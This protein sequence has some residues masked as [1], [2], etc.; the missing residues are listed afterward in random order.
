[1][2]KIPGSI[3]LILRGNVVRRLLPHVQAPCSCARPSPAAAGAAGK[4]AGPSM[5]TAAARCLIL[6]LLLSLSGCALFQKTPPVVRPAPVRQVTVAR[7]ERPEP[8]EV[9]P[10]EPPKPDAGPLLHK[11]RPKGGR[12]RPQP[13]Q[14]ADKTHY[15]LL[16][17]N[18][19][20]EKGIASWYGPS[21]QGRRTSCGE[22]FDMHKVS[23]AHKLLPMHTRIQVTNLENGKAIDLTVNDRGPYVTGR[24]LDLSYGAAKALGVVDKGLARVRICTFDALP[25]ERN[26]DLAG[27]FLIHIGSFEK[28]ADALVLLKDMKS[29]NYKPSLLKVVTS[30]RG[31]ETRFRVEVGPYGSMSAANR[32]HSRVIGDYPSAFVVAR[33]DEEV[34]VAASRWGTQPAH[35]DLR[36]RG[37][38]PLRQ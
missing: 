36:E 8:P 35:A 13:H 6:P 1:M 7:T 24:V 25:G 26:G 4:E 34:R 32:A 21:F 12:G 37:S 19:Y 33:Q 15:P 28:E 9:I 11:H 14:P 5:R 20:E 38:L 16:T 3:L 27:V 31:G 2:H 18:G 23:A 30:H 17:A 22:V 10:P 29:L